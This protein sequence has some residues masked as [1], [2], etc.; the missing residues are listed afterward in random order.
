MAYNSDHEI[1][2]YFPIQRAQSAT[3]YYNYDSLLK[4]R[5]NT[6]DR[7]EDRKKRSANFFFYQDESGV[8]SF[9]TILSENAV[10]SRLKLEVKV[11][12]TST[13]KILLR[14]G[15]TDKSVSWNPTTTTATGDLKWKG[16]TKGFVIGP[17]TNSKDRERS[18]VTVKILDHPVN[19]DF[20]V[21][22]GHVK[23][24]SL[25]TNPEALNFYE[26]DAT[27][28]STIK[29]C[30]IQCSC[31]KPETI[32][33]LKG[34]I[35]SLSTEYGTSYTFKSG[36]GILTQRYSDT[37]KCS[38]IL[39]PPDVA[40]IGFQFVNWDIARGDAIT[41]YRGDS[42]A[43]GTKLIDTYSDPVSPGPRWFPGN[44]GG[45]VFE[46]NND[47]RSTGG[48]VLKLNHAHL[49]FRFRLRFVAIPTLISTSPNAGSYLL[50]NN[51]RL[52]GK[53]FVP[54]SILVKVGSILISNVQ[55]LSNSQIE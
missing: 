28:N 33:T 50:T 17:V 36:S 23:S 52:T 16:T 30:R 40:G 46:P 42:L 25:A 54:G 11:E 12:S 48:C 19:V 26:Y 47:G 24:S 31:A 29:I 20:L 2:E 49:L 18:C 38:W 7:L 32:T 21:V 6:N 34:E 9:T 3:S 22:H 55:W 35:E 5:A 43:T 4:G 45:V 51:I 37:T 44:K 39:A 41:L 8:V 15:P 13:P 14:D 10:D 27:V 1:A 53:N